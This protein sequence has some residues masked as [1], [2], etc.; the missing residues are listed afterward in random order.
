MKQIELK[1]KKSRERGKKNIYL[2]KNSEGC[3]G[4]NDTQKKFAGLIL[5]L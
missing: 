1:T 5:N 3:K 4:V 2:K